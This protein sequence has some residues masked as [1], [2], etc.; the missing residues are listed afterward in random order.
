MGLSE[1]RLPKNINVFIIKFSIKMTIWSHLEPFGSIYGYPGQPHSW[2]QKIPR[3][4]SPRLRPR[5]HSLAGS[6]E[7]SLECHRQSHLYP[8]KLGLW[9]W[10]LDYQISTGWGGC[11]TQT[12]PNSFPKTKL[13]ELHL[14]QCLYGCWLKPHLQGLSGGWRQT[15]QIQNA[16]SHILGTIWPW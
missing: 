14:C 1:S 7:I 8:R 5:D 10:T 15:S 16:A 2:L 12:A 9:K 6:F 4:K 11:N 3:R 13:I